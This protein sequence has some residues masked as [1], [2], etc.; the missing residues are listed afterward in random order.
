[1]VGHMMP[2][3]ISL[4]AQAPPEIP[5]HQGKKPGFASVPHR[6]LLRKYGQ[7]LRRRCGSAE[8]RDLHHLPILPIRNALDRGPV[9]EANRLPE[10]EPSATGAGM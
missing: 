3:L 10:L 2:S 6:A 8:G 7:G 4:N 9:G 1:M 5:G